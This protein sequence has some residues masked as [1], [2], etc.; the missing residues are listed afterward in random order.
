M[1]YLTCNALY[2]DPAKMDAITK[3]SLPGSFGVHRLCV[4]VNYL[5]QFLSSLFKV[6]R[7]GKKSYRTLGDS[8]TNDS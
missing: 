1:G 3:L 6:M 2:P 7:K 8:D 4:T 5:A